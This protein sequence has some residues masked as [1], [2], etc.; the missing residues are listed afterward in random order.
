MTAT[1]ARPTGDLRAAQRELEDAL[2][3]SSAAS[4]PTPAGLGVTVAWGLPYFE[5]YVPAAWREARAARPP[6]AASRRC[7]R[8][9]PLP[10]RPARRPILEENDVAVLLRSDPLDHVADGAKAIF[11]DLDVLEPTSIRK[12]FAGG[13]FDGGRACRSRWRWR[14]ACRGADLIP[15]TSELFLGFTSTQKAGLG[16]RP[17]RE[18]RDARLRRPAGGYFRARHAHAPLAH[19]R[20]PRGVVPELRL[21]AS[22]STPS[23]RP[24]LHVRGGHADRAAGARRERD[25]GRGRRARLPPRRTDRPQRLDP[26]DLA[27]ATGH[28]V[29]RTGRSTARARRSRSA[30]TSTRSTT[31]SSG[32]R[33][34]DGRSTRPSAGVHFVVFNPT[35]DDFHRNRLAMDGVL[36]DGTSLPSRAAAT[37]GQG[38]NSVLHTTHRQN[39]LVP[40]RR[41]RCLPAGRAL[42]P[43]AAQ[44][45]NASRDVVPAPRGTVFSS[46][47]ASVERDVDDRRRRGSAA[48]RPK[49][50]LVDEVGRL[51]SEAR[52]EHAVARGR[53]A[54]ALDVAEHGDARLE[55]GSLLDLARPSAVA[56]A[57]ERGRGRTGRRRASRLVAR[58]TRT[59]A[60]TPR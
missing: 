38:F 4:P 16:P 50:A 59:S 48:I 11:E 58:P 56:D 14:R 25:A 34:R 2:A 42:T 26:D 43:R 36:P 10:E 40:P 37:R 41:H 35:S 46:A 55:A 28:V 54:A 39:F 6:R 5:R 7:C 57:A 29:G 53:R 60:R 23:F 22:A 44:P 47:V 30:P 24:G 21:P 31:R 49:L 52:R 9:D 32:A 3:G 33:R 15:D 51:Q 13:G 18:P 17:D 45:K 1:R 19:L 8:R 20:G 27:A 12:G